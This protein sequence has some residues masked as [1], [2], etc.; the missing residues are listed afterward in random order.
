M[1]IVDELPHNERLV[2]AFSR[3]FGSILMELR[4]HDLNQKTQVKPTPVSEKSNLEIVRSSE[5]RR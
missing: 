2:N 4:Y 5:W 3:F 1:N